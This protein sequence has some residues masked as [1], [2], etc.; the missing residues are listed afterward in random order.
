MVNFLLLYVNEK[1]LT[2]DLRC[3]DYH[4]FELVQNETENK[5]LLFVMLRAYYDSEDHWTY[6]YFV[7]IFLLSDIG[8]MIGNVLKKYFLLF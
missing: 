3:D 5:I 1:K 2:T 6:K 8:T 7:I 4:K